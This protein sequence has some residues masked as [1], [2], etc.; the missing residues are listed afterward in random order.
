MTPTGMD[1]PVI[2]VILRRFVFAVIIA[3]FNWNPLL[4]SSQF[5]DVSLFVR[6]YGQA[7]NAES[8]S[9]LQLAYDVRGVFNRCPLSA[10]TILSV[11]TCNSYISPP[12]VIHRLTFSVF[13]NS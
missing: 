6:D 1:D 12:C 3:V 7:L 8:C 2:F 9:A 11:P 10:S 4:I 13:A 5:R